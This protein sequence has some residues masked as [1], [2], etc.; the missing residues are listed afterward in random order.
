MR[1]KSIFETEAY[2]KEGAKRY[3]SETII[4]GIYYTPSSWMQP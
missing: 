3:C 4:P 1:P 2:K